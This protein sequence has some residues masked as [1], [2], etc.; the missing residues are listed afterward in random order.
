MTLGDFHRSAAVE[1]HRQ[2]PNS[3]ADAG[4]LLVE[5]CTRQNL[6]PPKNPPQFVKYWKDRMTKKGNILSRAHMSGCKFKV[7]T[8]QVQLAYNAIIGWEAA[9]RERPYESAKD[10]AAECA[11]VKKLLALTGVH[12]TTLISRIKALHPKFGRKK[13][14]TRWVLSEENRLERLD[15]ALQLKAKEQAE[16]QKVVH[17]DA[18]TV[19]MQEKSIFGYVDLAVGYNIASTKPAKKRGKVIKL[20]YYAAVNAK[21]GAFFIR[22]YTG[23]TDMP[24]TRQGLNYKVSSGAE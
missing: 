2:R 17:L 6:D 9:G 12:I 7:T 22:F 23:T 13:L 16:L 1:A 19:Y 5:M 4:R 10:I 11:P 15:V 3:L 14:R 21:L 8:R 24:A 20:K 18:K